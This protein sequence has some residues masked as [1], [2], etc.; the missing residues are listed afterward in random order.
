MRGDIQCRIYLV[1]G[2]QPTSSKSGPFSCSLWTSSRRLVPGTWSVSQLCF[3]HCEWNSVMFQQCDSNRG[4]QTSLTLH[5]NICILIWLP[6]VH[7]LVGRTAPVTCSLF[8]FANIWP[9]EAVL[10]ITSS[11][12]APRGYLLP[13]LWEYTY[14]QMLWLLGV[15]SEIGPSPWRMEAKEPLNVWIPPGSVCIGSLQ[16]AEHLL[17]SGYVNSLQGSSQSGEPGEGRLME[18]WILGQSRESSC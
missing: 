11:V 10:V 7:A 12:K 8:H 4:P 16:Q 6:G 14:S 9:R 3:F 5:Q 2:K 18:T 1:F 13:G 17:F 15:T